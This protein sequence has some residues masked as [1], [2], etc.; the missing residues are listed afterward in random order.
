M[1]SEQTHPIKVVSLRTGLSPHVIRVWERRYGAVHPARTDSN[2]RL[3]SDKD[4][5]RLALLK[6]ASNLGE[7]ISQMAKLTDGQLRELIGSQP[8]AVLRAIPSGTT[9][10]GSAAAAIYLQRCLEAVERFDADGLEAMLLRASADLSQPVLINDLVEPMMYRIGEMWSQ[11]TI[12]ISHEHMASAIVRSLLGNM[13]GAYRM[14]GAAPCLIATTPAGQLHEF[15]A[16]IATI[17]A[18]SAGWRAYY[19]GPNMP[20]ADIASSVQQGRTDAVALSIVYPDDDPRLHQ[21][22]VNVRRLVGD[23]KPILVGGRASGAYAETL[24][25]INAIRV[26]GLTDLRQKLDT[27]RSG[28]NGGPKTLT[29]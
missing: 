19:L 1:E 22:L 14:N 26:E 6:S 2:R 13:A 24:R 25:S 12:K 28:G 16:L 11:G 7:S 3:Y 21:E 29:A 27:I 5:E 4:I 10:N 8:A 15:G 20:A 18:A 17:V 9:T 23:G